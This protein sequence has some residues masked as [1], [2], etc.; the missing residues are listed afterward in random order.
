MQIGF[1]CPINGVQIVGEWS[2]DA[3]IL[4]FELEDEDRDSEHCPPHLIEESKLWCEKHSGRYFGDV[5]EV[6]EYLS[7]I[8]VFDAVFF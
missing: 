3:G 5:S 2:E 1:Q 6:Q 4:N 7:H 8:N